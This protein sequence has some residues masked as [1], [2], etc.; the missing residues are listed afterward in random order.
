M[1]EYRIS[2][3]VYEQIKD[4]YAS[5]LTKE[6]ELL[7]DNLILNKEINERYKTYGLCK[8]CKQPRSSNNWCRPC[9]SKRFQQDFKNWTSGNHIIDE[10]IQRIQLEAN[11]FYEILEWTEYNAFENVEYLDLQLLIKQ[12][13]K[14]QDLYY[15][16]ILKIMDGLD[17]WKEELL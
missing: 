7:V 6:Q 10:F 14:N 4:F 2:D 17:T 15:R 11:G 5:T 13:G 16:G 8:G 9:A 12:C 3:E 1:E